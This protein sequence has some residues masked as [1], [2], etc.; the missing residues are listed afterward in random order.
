VRLGPGD[1]AVLNMLLW[2]CSV[3][4]R[5]TLA[6]VFRL[7][8]LTH[9]ASINKRLRALVAADLIQHSKA[10]CRPLLDLKEPLYSC[11]PANER[12]AF[13]R[14]GELAWKLEKRWKDQSLAPACLYHAGK[15][16][17]A[18]HGGVMKGSLKQYAHLS[19]DTQCAW[20]YAYYLATN[21]TLARTIV[22]EHARLETIRSQKVPDFVC[23]DSENRPVLALE[24][25]GFYPADKITS[26]FRDLERRRLALELW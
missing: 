23:H 17:I 5:S 19:H 13:S 25:G 26:L 1:M 10:L 2:Q 15:K 22:S 3:A 16:A 6:E 11:N 12:Y 14:A 8:G 9:A 18:I 7:N 20:L 24:V 4:R 21:P